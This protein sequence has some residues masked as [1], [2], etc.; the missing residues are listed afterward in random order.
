MADSITSLSYGS[1][2]ASSSTSASGASATSS[3][4]SYNPAPYASAWTAKERSFLRSVNVGLYIG[5]ALLGELVSTP[6]TQA[7]SLTNPGP[8]QAYTPSRSGARS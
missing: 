8:I 3:S 6:L 5:A 1:V 7:L 2:A 4:I